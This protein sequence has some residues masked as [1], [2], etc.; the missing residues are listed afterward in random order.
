MEI[1]TIPSNLHIEDSTLSC[2]CCNGILEKEIKN[3][4]YL[5]REC[6]YCRYSNRAFATYSSSWQQHFPNGCTCEDERCEKE[7][8]YITCVKCESPKCIKCNHKGDCCNKNCNSFLCLDCDK[9]N[10]FN[11]AWKTSSPQEKLNLYGIEK[12]KILAKNKNIGI[13]KYKKQE[14]INILSPLVNEK[15]FPIK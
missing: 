6:G 12:L 2:P 8:I 4:R 11:N 5:S 13:S 1:R 14:L 15:D 7:F 9:K 3:V 10:N